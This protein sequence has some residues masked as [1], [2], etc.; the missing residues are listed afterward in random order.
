[1]A[2]MT[3]S[4]LPIASSTCHVNDVD[5]F[6]RRIGVNKPP[7]IALHGLM[8]SGACLLPLA[9]TLQDEFEVFVPDARGHG[10]SSA[11]AS[12][13]R[14]DNL[15]SDVI[16]LI[17]ELRLDKPVLLGHSMGGLTAAVAATRSESPLR[18]LVLV[19]P[20]F[21]SL[22]YQ[23]EV[24]ESPVAAEHEQALRSPRSDLLVQA[25]LRSPRRSAELIEHLVDARLHTSQHAF[26]VLRP[27]NPP[28][29]ELVAHL[30]MPTLLLLADKGVVSIETA[31][32]LH[33][34]NPLVRYELIEDAGHGIPYD[35]PERVGAAVSRFLRE[36][37]LSD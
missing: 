16:A 32:E 31:R 22:D 6:Y 37:A 7:L 4:A 21:I 30:T 9:R 15:A 3:G 23:R 11:P 10:G 14:Y 34:L 20:T 19:D 24:F 13:Y 25:R 27:P 33:S 5:I 8:G 18:A 29:R 1:M 2:D 36:R 28:W 35:H 26:E 12:G 17:K